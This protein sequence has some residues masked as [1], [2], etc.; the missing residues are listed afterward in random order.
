MYGTVLI[1]KVRCITETIIGEEQCGF[2][3]SRECVDQVFMVRQLSERFVSKG[4][5]LHVSCM[6]LGKAYGRSDREAMWQVFRMY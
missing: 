3:R 4:K 5:R 6:D 1:E 2:R